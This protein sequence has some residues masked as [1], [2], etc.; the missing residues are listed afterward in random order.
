M[1]IGQIFANWMEN[2]ISFQVGEMVECSF[3]LGLSHLAISAKS[4]RPLKLTL[5]KW[6]FLLFQVCIVSFGTWIYYY[7]V[8]QWTN[9]GFCVELDAKIT[10]TLVAQEVLKILR[11]NS[12]LNYAA[13]IWSSSYQ[14]VIGRLE[15]ITHKFLFSIKNLIIR[16]NQLI[17]WMKRFSCTS[18]WH[19]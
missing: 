12:V 5:V 16:S 7:C 10:T 14:N 8:K 13:I 11:I 1:F 2:K 3:L 18:F 4:D 15:V 6:P 17:I 9:D 19:L